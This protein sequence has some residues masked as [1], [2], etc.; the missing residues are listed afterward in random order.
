MMKTK[1]ERLAVV[2]GGAALF[3]S[4]A[5]PV[6][7]LADTRAASVSADELSS[8]SKRNGDYGAGYTGGGFGD[9][10]FKS[11]GYGGRGYSSGGF[12]DRNFKSGGFAARHSAGRGH[13]RHVRGGFADRSIRS[14]GYR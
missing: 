2:V 3:A 8:R 7:A 14:L 5:M 12:G 4:L 9:R 6:S 13:G 10:S 1:F 11:R